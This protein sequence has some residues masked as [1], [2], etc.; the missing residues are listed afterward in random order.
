MNSIVA[1]T[2]AIG[3][4]C[5]ALG[6]HAAR[7]QDRDGEYGRLGTEEDEVEARAGDPVFRPARGRMDNNLSIWGIFSYAYSVGTGLGVGVRYQKTLVPE[8]FLRNA[9]ISD[10]LGVEGSLEY[11]HY[12]WD[13]ITEGSYNELDIAAGVVWNLWLSE[14]FAVYPKLGLGVGIG[15]WDDD[16]YDTGGYGGVFVLAAAG[17]V[18]QIDSLTLRAEL[19]TNALQLGI[20]FTP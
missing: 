10:D 4:L 12:E 14:Q 16:D 20:G 19:G 13:F 17:V 8:G 7:A 11:R 18:Y 2:I 6:S 3:L 1:R 9:E 5:I 15:F